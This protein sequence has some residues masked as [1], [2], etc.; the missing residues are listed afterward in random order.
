VPA[1]PPRA[2]A[3]T[4]AVVESFFSPLSFE[5]DLVGMNGRKGLF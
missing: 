5:L 3:G 2:A 4:Y 1:C